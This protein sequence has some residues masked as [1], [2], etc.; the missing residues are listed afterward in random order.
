MQRAH[1]A[2]RPPERTDRA[3]E[4]AAA[5]PA[6]AA[7]VL[8]LQ[9]QMGNRAVGRMLAREPK[10]PPQGPVTSGVSAPMSL[11]DFKSEMLRYGVASIVTVD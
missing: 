6:A 8:T 2:E 4:P 7:R 9:R 3:G 11:Q 1:Q 10:A 5:V